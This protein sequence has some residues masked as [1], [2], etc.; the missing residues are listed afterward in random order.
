MIL[1]PFGVVLV[2][3]FLLHCG[4]SQWQGGVHA[5]FRFSQSHGLRVIDIP[6]RG[7]AVEAG[8]RRGD[9]VIMVD[10]E[11]VAH[12]TL[13]EVVERLRGPVGTIVKLTV[14]RD[15]KQSTLSIER[16]PYN[17]DSSVF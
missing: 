9:R 4:P 11:D 8:L 2:G 13:K 1:R 14:I 3:M 16:A 5:E 12:M 15:G 7:P 10:K 6:A 17:D